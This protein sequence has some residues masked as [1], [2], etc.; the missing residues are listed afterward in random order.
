VFILSIILSI[1]LAVSPK[2]PVVTHYPEDKSAVVDSTI[3][4]ATLADRII[5]EAKRHLGKPYSY[6]SPGPRAFDCSGLT[7]YVY[8]Q[9]GYELTRSS[10][11]QAH[12]GRPVTGHFSDLQ[13]GD[14]LIFG[15]RRNSGV[16]GHVG[17][18][19]ALD[20][21]GTDFVFIHAARSGVRYNSYKESYYNDRLLGVRRIIPD[22]VKDEAEDPIESI[23]DKFEK[24]PTPSD[25]AMSALISGIANSLPDSTVAP[26]D[27]VSHAEALMSDASS[28]KGDV[29]LADAG[30][31]KGEEAPKSGR[32]IDP[33]IP[34]L[35][36]RS[37]K[38][39]PSAPQSSTGSV[40]SFHTI[41][42]G[43][44]LSG[45][46]KTYHTTVR[47]VCRL[48]GISTKTTLRVGRKLRV[49]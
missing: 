49:K 43:D 23:L 22:I 8:R 34:E 6:G 5:E 32:H 33:P 40:G 46:A 27:T 11:S 24:A 19:I 7:S 14:I 1:F 12:D 48:N 42:S 15:S 2:I 31:T 13:K 39:Q 10:S 21:T 36:R 44:T 20:S 45:I 25:L 28:K 18:F 29:L 35:G 37:Y 17:I 4:A 30:E 26:L 9:F 16:I 3:D 38:T 47:E 41:R